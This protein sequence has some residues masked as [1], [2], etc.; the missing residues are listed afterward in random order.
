[1][2]KRSKKASNHI[3]EIRKRITLKKRLQVMFEMEWLN[4]NVPANRFH[5]DKE[6]KQSVK[7]AK[8]MIERVG[9][10]IKSYKQYK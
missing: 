2:K 10:T 4:M 6:A 9:Q 7:W 1:M 3:L 8:H 5:T